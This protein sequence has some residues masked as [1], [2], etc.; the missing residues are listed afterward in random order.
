MPDVRALSGLKAGISLQQACELMTDAFRAAGIDEPQTDARIL[1]AHALGLS[2]AQLI[3][4]GDR[5][6]ET[7]EI[8]A[9][10]TRTARRLAR[11]P[12]S[13]IIGRREFWGL[14]LTINSSVLDPR[15]ETETLVE[16]ALDW[17]AT[18]H[19]RN[20]SLRVLDIGT[21][22]GALLLALLSEL[23]QATGVATD[24]SVAALTLARSNARRLGLGDRGSFIACNFSDALRGSFDLVVSNPPYISSADIAGLEPEVRNHDPVTA[25]DG[26]PDA[27]NAYR[28]IAADALR[29]LV[30]RGRLILELGQDQAVNVSAIV[31]DA[32]LLIETPVH[33]D[34]AGIS[35]ALCA[36]A[37]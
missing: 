1:A 28:A 25:L 30:P 37:P 8:E 19:L 29:L 7:R 14:T 9:I 6:L 2:R 22:S 11:E 12:V 34:L 36:T 32:G 31:R 3:S 15:P 5:E 4:Q 17:I 35:R 24:I 10:S 23:P 16:V 13:R 26:G 18:R 33:P 27:L 21:G 20:E